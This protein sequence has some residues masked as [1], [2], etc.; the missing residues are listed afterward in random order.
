MESER[1]DWYCYWYGHLYCHCHPVLTLGLEASN[2]GD[3]IRLHSFLVSSFMHFFVPALKNHHMLSIY[4]LHDYYSTTT[5]HNIQQVDICQ[6][7]HV[8]TSTTTQ[9]SPVAE[10]ILPSYNSLPSC[11]PWWLQVQL[12]VDTYVINMLDQNFSAWSIWL[13]GIVPCTTP[14]CLHIS[15]IV[16]FR[17]CV[18]AVSVASD[19]VVLLTIMSSQLPHDIIKTAVSE[20][21]DIGNGK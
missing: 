13:L 16:W 1:S 8:Q 17:V 11:V 5:S 21:A 3:T 14:S 7:L 4:T 12:I 20:P 10:F 2:F 9:P 18:E 6:I 15:C 19:I